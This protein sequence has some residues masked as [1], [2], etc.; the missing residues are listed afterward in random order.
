MEPRQ[1]QF[2]L[3]YFVATVLALLAL[4]NVLFGPHTANLSYS[5]FKAL[6]RAGKVADLTLRERAI[7]GTLKP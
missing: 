6:L 3:W 4:Q 5:D 7:V 1:K 2:S